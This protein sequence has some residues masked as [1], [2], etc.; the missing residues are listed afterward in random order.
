MNTMCM[1]YRSTYASDF[2]PNRLSDIGKPTSKGTAQ[3]SL[4]TEKSVDREPPIISRPPRRRSESADYRIGARRS[5]ISDAPSSI[6]DIEKR[7]ALLNA[8]SC[9]PTKTRSTTSTAMDA[10]MTQTAASSVLCRLDFI[11]SEMQGASAPSVQLRAFVRAATSRNA[12][13]FDSVRHVSSIV[14]RAAESTTKLSS[15]KRSLSGRLSGSLLSPASRPNPTKSIKSNNSTKT[16]DSNHPVRG[17]SGVCG[18]QNIGN[19][20]YQN[21]VIQFLNAIPEFTNCLREVEVQ[22]DIA[23]LMDDRCGSVTSGF[24]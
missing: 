17:G 1:L 20:C 18:I 21:S 11:V 4:P 6:R 8:S 13:S 7:M 3:L 9:L 15:L 10:D 16:D 23:S 5:S 14:P 22:K 19:S 24:E 12:S 2:A